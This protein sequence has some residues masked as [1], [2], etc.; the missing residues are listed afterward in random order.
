[1]QGMYVL[2]IKRFA[3]HSKWANIRHIKA[4]KDVE[5]SRIFTKLGTQMKVAIQEGGSSDPI[6]NIKLA[7]VV[8]QA[9]RVN[10]PVATIQNIIKSTQKDKDQSKTY[11][12]GV[13]GPG[14]S[15]ILCEAF[16]S[17]LPSLK[18]QMATILKKN[19]G[20]FLDGN[21]SHLF[22]QKGVIDIEITSSGGTHEEILEN[23]TDDALECEADDVEI[24][25]ETNCLRFLC[26]PNHLDKVQKSLATKGYKIRSASIEYLP[27]KLV[28]LTDSEIDQCSIL[29]EKLENMENIVKVYDNIC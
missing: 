11:L 25:E 8:E 29:L 14:K 4:Q 12:I 23:A 13:K 3:G 26:D 1:M 10:M 24:V 19:N 15:I 21:F 27:Q 17:S 20:K 16:T 18:I 5:R 6:N 9:K 28:E 7:H 22:I 2:I